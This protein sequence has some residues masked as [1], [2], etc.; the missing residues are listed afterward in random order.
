MENIPEAVKKCLKVLEENIEILSDLELDL[1][2]GK[3]DEIV[4]D[5]KLHDLYDMTEDVA[6]ST[7]L[8]R[9][10]MNYIRRKII[11]V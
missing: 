4:Y 7:K 11:D 8:K 9:A 3:E 5:M 10:E 1:K 6:E 2:D